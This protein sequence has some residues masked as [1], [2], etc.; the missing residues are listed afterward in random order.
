MDQKL[1]YRFALLLAGLTGFFAGIALTLIVLELTA[2]APR[3]PA[4][5]QSTILW[6]S[7]AGAD[8]LAKWS[9][10]DGGGI[11]NSGTGT[12]TLANNIKH[13]GNPAIA[14]TI[15]NAN[16]REQAARIFRWG[17]NPVEAYY[18]V[19]LYFPQFYDPDEW[20]N[21]FQF[22]SKSESN[23]PT[24]VLNVG[25]L[26]DGYMRFYLWDDINSKSYNNQLVKP[27]KRIPV[28]CWVHVEVFYRR[29]ME[30]NGQIIVWQDGVKLYD[31]NGVETALADNIQWGLSNY[32][33][34]IRPSTATIYAADAVISKA[35]LGPGNG[36]LCS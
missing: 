30:E 11:F 36:P 26:P 29:S 21:V 8:V 2:P 28:A 15:S 19:W 32:T 27:A 20:W 1:E 10:D 18:S 33:D 9:A 5:P 23:R 22:K 6:T 25:N 16:G 12:V 35:R 4:G 24:W 3:T 13:N 34:Q 31:L 17:E 14:L 7:G